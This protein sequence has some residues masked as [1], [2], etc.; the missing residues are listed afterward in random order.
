[1][2]RTRMNPFLLRLLSR[3]EYVVEPTAVAEAMLMRLPRERSGG[4]GVSRMLVTLKRA[5]GLA[6]LPQE[7]DS[8]VA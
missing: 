1:M 7:G 4:G 3:G 2:A 8:R 6:A 5:D